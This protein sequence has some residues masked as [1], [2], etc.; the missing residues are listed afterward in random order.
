MNNQY[1]EN[2]EEYLCQVESWAQQYDDETVRFAV[3]ELT[4]MNRDLFYIFKETSGKL[5]ELRTIFKKHFP[6]E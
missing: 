6:N 1:D 3:L 2:F 4:Q 5:E